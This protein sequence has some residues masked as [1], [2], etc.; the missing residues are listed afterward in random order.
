MK[1]QEDVVVIGGGVIGVCAAYYL[2]G[3]GRE[4]TILERDDI[5]SGSSY[6]NSGLIV[7]THIVPLAAPGVIGTALKW[8]LSPESPFYI[9]PRLDPALA[10]WL[11]RFRAAC[12]ERKTKTSIPVMRDLGKAGAA[13]C[14]ELVRQEGLECDYQRNGHL[15]LYK[16]EH[17]LQDGFHE[18]R[19]LEEHGF[20]NRTLTPSEVTEMEPSVRP[21]IAGAVYCGDDANL[22][23]A[24]FVRQLATRFQ[25]K[26]GII[27]TGTEVLGF[28]TSGGEIVSVKTSRGEH[29]PRQV[30]LAAGAWSPSLARDLGL[31][32]AV[33]P[34]K[35]Y[36]VTFESPATLPS[37]PVRLG[38]AKVG[39]TP[40]GQMKRFAGT[41]ELSG[42]NLTIDSRRV[43]A[44]VRA[45][46]DYLTSEVERVSG[47]VWCGMRP[48][49]PDGL[50]MIGPSGTVTNLIVATGHATLGM[51]H[52]PITGK[53]VAQLACGKTPDVDTTALSPDRF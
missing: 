11:W 39:V 14:D 20:T 6:G 8:M 3:E 25:E 40:I 34:A 48:C 15:M 22:D 2:L 13:L 4:V 41:L 26:G 10:S 49:T 51:T 44:I 43:G 16:T 33:Q 18:A 5:C 50:P 38:E 46:G 21:D 30:V 12:N 42:L 32:L 29:R 17:G 31:K 9:K 37:L 36:S 35:G 19:L 52:G 28:D 27:Q 1:Q 47:D 24:S 23:P 7:P 53:L 45:V